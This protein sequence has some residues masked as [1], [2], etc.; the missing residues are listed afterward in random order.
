MRTAFTLLGAFF[1]LSGC[2]GWS[3][4]PSDKAPDNEYEKRIYQQQDA[5]EQQRETMLNAY[6]T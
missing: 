2:S 4:E 6:H 5:L 1:I 3:L